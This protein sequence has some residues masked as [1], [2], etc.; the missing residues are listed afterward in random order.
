MQ[1]TTI[2][3]PKKLL[4]VT[5]RQ[6]LDEG[7]SLQELIAQSIQ[8]RLDRKTFNEQV[9]TPNQGRQHATQLLNFV[10]KLEHSSAAGPSDLASKLDT[11][12]Y[13]G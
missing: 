1:K 6:A 3:L 4:V 11:Y 5:K 8:L 13:G 12:L 9:E 2:R 10:E 7:I